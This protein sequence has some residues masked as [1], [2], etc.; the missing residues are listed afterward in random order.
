MLSDCSTVS[1]RKLESKLFE[2]QTAGIERE[3][4]TETTPDT[5]VYFSSNPSEYITYIYFFF[6][7]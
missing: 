2:C 7:T 5:E 3:P 6:H 4:S 1:I